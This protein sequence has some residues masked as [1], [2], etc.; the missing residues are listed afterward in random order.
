MPDV[1]MQTLCSPWRK[2]RNTNETS[3]GYVSKVPRN[4]DPYVNANTTTKNGD[5]DTATG[6]SVINF[7]NSPNPSMPVQNGIQL[8]FYGVGA[9]DNTF[10]CRILGWANMCNDRANVFADSAQIWIPVV[11]A[12]V[13]VTLS[14]T[15]VG[16]AGANI[17]ATE[18][19]ADTITITGTT[20]NPGINCNIVSPAN[21]TIARMF[22]DAEGYQYIE[23]QFTTGGSATSCNGLY[24]P[25]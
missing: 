22:L 23:A 17:L 25:M 24:K 7:R 16:L 5:A 6:P 21:N 8:L 15:P 12:E 4:T 9:N 2:L 10:S 13:A 20:A 1:M 3:N 14:S 11:L 18:L 19:F